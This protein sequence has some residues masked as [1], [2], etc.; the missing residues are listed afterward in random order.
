MGK[1]TIVMLQLMASMTTTEK[2]VDETI[3]ALELYKK[4]GYKENEP[5]SQIMLL[6]IKFQQGDFM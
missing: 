3:E 2:L 4:E 6:I 5:Y 1:G